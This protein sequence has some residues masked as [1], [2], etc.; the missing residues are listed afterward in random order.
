M[1][2]K[3]LGRK[4]SHIADKHML[5]NGY[6]KT[7]ENRIVTD[8]EKYDDCFAY[9]EQIE[10]CKKKSGKHLVLSFEKVDS[11]KYKIYQCEKGEWVES[12]FSI[13]MGIEYNIVFWVWLKTIGLKW[14]Y[15][16]E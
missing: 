6:V 13:T 4:L 2:K 1:I 12:Y 7:E 15:N 14:E 5:K 8:Y 10:I 11:N 9:T 16:W 3:I